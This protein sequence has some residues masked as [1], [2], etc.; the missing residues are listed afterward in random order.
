[1]VHALSLHKNRI[2]NGDKAGNPCLEFTF[3]KMNKKMWARPVIHAL[4]L[5]TKIERDKASTL[6]LEVQELKGQGTY[7]TLMY[8]N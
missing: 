5:L 7:Y 3:K 2:K 4:I 8:K 1:M 6:C